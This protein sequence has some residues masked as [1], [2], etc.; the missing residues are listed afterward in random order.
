M[1]RQ[2]ANILAP[3]GAANAASAE[4]ALTLRPSELSEYLESCW[5]LRD[6]NLFEGLPPAPVQPPGP[7]VPPQAA[8]DALLRTMA[9]PV[10]LDAPPALPPPTGAVWPHLGYAFM[11]EQTRMVSAFRRLLEMYVNG[12]MRIA[13]WQTRNWI[14]GTEELFFASPRLPSVYLL[15]SHLR[16]DSGT[17]RRNAYFLVVGMEL[18]SVFAF[19]SQGEEVC[20]PSPCTAARPKVTL[21]Q[22][23]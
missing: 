6:Q 19:H 16:S 20:F 12:A 10:A 9:R 21:Q 4:L 5:L 17:R 18:S 15:E 13:S 7:Q 8:E 11:L 2:L 22:V 23:H 1:F 3:G 14:R